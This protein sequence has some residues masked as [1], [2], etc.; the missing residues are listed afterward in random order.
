MAIR[1]IR[2]VGLNEL[3][4][5]SNWD[6][7]AQPEIDDVVVTL[8]KRIDRQGKGLG[9]QRNP[10]LSHRRTADGLTVQSSLNRPRTKGT[11]WGRK[12]ERVLPAVGRNAMAKAVRNIEARWGA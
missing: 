2:V 8:G 5:K 10:N 11:A 7:L 4:A 1:T 6:V 9:A 12:N 3:L